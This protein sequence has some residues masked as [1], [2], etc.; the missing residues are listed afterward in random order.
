MIVGVP[1]EMKQGEHRV[2]MI[3]AG[4]EEL[5]RAGHTVLVQSQA[6][7]GSGV[8]DDHYR[9]AGA[10]VVES[11]RDV[12]AR[13]ELVV[14]VKE[15]LPVET[16]MTHPGQVVF[17][18]YHF[19]ADRALTEAVLGSGIVAIAYETIRDRH[20]RLPLLKPMSEIAGKL[21]IQ[22][23]AR[24]LALP[25]TGR[26]ILLGGVPGVEGGTVLI[27]GGGVVGSNAARSAAGLGARAIVLD[28]DIDRLRHLRDIMPPNVEAI[29]CD[30][31]TI[32][33]YLPQ[34][35]LVVGAVLIPGSRCPTLVHREDLKRMKPGA[36]I[37]DV[38]VDQ[39]GCVEST[40]PTTHSDPTYVVEN[41]MHY[42]VTN[43]AAAVPR[44]STFALCNATLP[45]VLTL[46]NLGYRRAASL[47][48]G[49]AA[50]ISV[51]DGRLID[52]AVAQAFGMD[53]HRAS[54]SL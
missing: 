28:V 7:I 41:V 16:A 14:K 27:L 19:A 8:L 38:D 47:D 10:E 23:G 40:R 17:A 54:L 21:S 36:V 18:Y 35:D 37:V 46:A 53:F 51:Q 39:G 50:G 52:E 25:M 26:G 1:R 43:M 6:G 44:T 4:V 45:Y 31:V 24:C 3:P 32:R 5:T 42:A 29:Y 20:G 11:A 2:G 34:A 9:A 48:P 13:A 22:E 49:L 33:H 30:P 12:F 15:P